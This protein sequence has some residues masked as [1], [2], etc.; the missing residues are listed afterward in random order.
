MVGTF[1]GPTA[2]QGSLSIHGQGITHKGKRAGIG[3]LLGLGKTFH[4]RE[5]GLQG[6]SAP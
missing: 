2:R 3:K 5:E 4:F 1:S 6:E